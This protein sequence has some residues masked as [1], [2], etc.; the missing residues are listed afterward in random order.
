MIPGAL[1][2][3]GTWKQGVSEATRS[4]WR[5]AHRMPRGTSNWVILRDSPLGASSVVGV[6]GDRWGQANVHR[7]HATPAAPTKAASMRI[8]MAY[9]CEIPQTS[10]ERA[11]TSAQFQTPKPVRQCPVRSGL[12]FGVQLSHLHAGRDPPFGYLSRPAL[13]VLVYCGRGGEPSG[14]NFA[15]SD[16]NQ[17]TAAAST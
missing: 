8:C 1:I 15:R 17:A 10:W 12:F 14:N 7:D 6:S 2:G 3:K 13:E 5:P 9:V 4:A 16:G 11:L